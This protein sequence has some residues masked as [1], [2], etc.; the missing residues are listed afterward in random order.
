MIGRSTVESIQSGRLYGFAAQVDGCAGASWTSSGAATVIA[1]GRPGRAHRPAIAKPSTTWSRGSPCTDCASSTSGTSLGRRDG[2]C[3][4][5]DP[6]P[7]PLRPHAEAADGGRRAG[8]ARPGE[9][10]GDD[11]AVAGRVMLL[12]DP[13]ASW[14]SPSCATRRARSSCSPR[15]GRPS[16]SRSSPSSTWATG[17]ARAA[18][19]CAPSAASCRCKV[20]EWVLLAE[21]RRNFGDKWR[22]VTD[23]ETRYR[24]REVDLWANEPAARAP[25]LR[26]DVVR[27]LRERLWAAG[28][29]E[30]ETPI[31]HPIPAGPTAR[32]FVTH[33]NALDA[34]FYLRIAPEL[35][36][37]RLVVGGFEQVFEIGRRLPQRGHLAA[38][39]PRVHDARALPGLRRL[40]RHDGAHR[41][42]GGRA[43]PRRA[44]APRSSPTRA[45]PSTSPRRG[46]APRW[47]S[48]SPRRPA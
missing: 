2:R 11:V 5:A 26:S 46:A 25:R 3:R 43:G 32:P 42:A 18:R 22:G 34:D 39:Q 37:K 1:T 6:G 41:G 40:H 7:L 19:W 9:E 16:A 15:R 17:S 8:R 4:G 47:P 44:A 13:R 14:P 24:Q 33:H 23:V 36:L 31:L 12:R 27:R 30:V 21:A 20:A 29:V 38:P 35:Y 45:A 48:W 10:S 28:F